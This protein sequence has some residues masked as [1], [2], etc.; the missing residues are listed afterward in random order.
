MK[1]EI[2]VSV[3]IPI[4]NTAPYLHRCF[5][6]VVRALGMLSYEVL[7]MDDGS[8]DGSAD[9][10]EAYAE[11]H[12]GFAFHRLHHGGQS[13]ARNTGLIYAKGKYIHF[14]DSDDFLA[15]GI[16]EDMFAAAEAE[17][18][19]FAMCNG[20]LFDKGKLVF[21][22]YEL[23]CFSHIG[24]EERVTN[25]RQ[26]PYLVMETT[27]T[28][29]LIRRDFLNSHGI[30]F[31][32]IQVFEDMLPV[33]K[34]YHYAQ[35]I[36]ILRTRGYVYRIRE[37]LSNTIRKVDYRHFH[38]KLK[39]MHG[40]FRFAEENE[41]PAE[42][43]LLLEYKA[44]NG[45]FTYFI[46][47]LSEFG[48]DTEKMVE[49]LAGLIRECISEETIARLPLSFR[50]IVRDVLDHDIAHLH[51]VIA[52]KNTD[53]GKAPVVRAD[54]GELE[55]RPD[56][57]IIR[58]PE[59]SAA[60]DFAFSVP[61]SSIQSIDRVG[62]S[63]V[64]TGHLYTNRYS[65]EKTEDQKIAAYLQNERTG[66][67]IEIPLTRVRSEYLT[68]M[69]YSPDD[70][71]HYNY[72]EAGFRLEIDFEDIA[73]DD[74]FLGK[75][76]IVLKYKTSLFSGW[77]VLRGFSGE[78]RKAC[79]DIRIIMD[80]RHISLWEE[81]EGTLDVVISA[82]EVNSGTEAAIR[83]LKAENQSLLEEND[84]LLKSNE[85]ALNKCQEL[86]WQNGLK[87]KELEKAKKRLQDVRD[88]YE[89]KSKMYDSAV[90]E[91]KGIISRLEAAASKLERADVIRAGDG[92]VYVKKSFTIVYHMDDST[93]PSP[94]STTVVF[95]VLTKTKTVSELGFEREGKVFAGWKAHREMD[96]T[97][98]LKDGDGKNAFKKLEGGRLPA[99]HRFVLYKN[100]EAVKRTATAGIVHFYAQW[101]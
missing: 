65:L 25:L 91:T 92:V 17:D 29:K 2:D 39:V 60:N 63:L 72:D 44:V 78:A 101:K 73:A 6:S 96:D 56:G 8:T 31:P 1:S 3:I 27:I 88:E 7:L 66:R 9:V 30:R 98:F 57:D 20:M 87:E 64:I 49:E 18:A 15:P 43:R 23:R 74:G 83:S 89:V 85:K 34:L 11:S 45:D 19:D 42:A 50:Q 37:D 54:G 82:P 71:V 41:I 10:A 36:A 51:E 76:L 80:N 68:K 22:V 94:L 61:I 86:L 13:N 75:N 93:A 77:R 69:K 47:H 33:L 95:D 59:R 28:H 52:Y 67:Y 58:I 55:I 90:N 12:E 32:Q 46:N 81:Q 100:G 5:D 53:Y 62:F 24:I 40:I 26:N 97:W 84:L 4:Y 48:D 21:N 79:P 99:G 70:E 38:E 14:M 16:I 35:R